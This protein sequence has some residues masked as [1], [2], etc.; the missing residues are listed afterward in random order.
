LLVGATHLPGLASDVELAKAYEIVTIS[1]V[2]PQAAIVRDM[3]AFGRKLKT[4]K[5]LKS[6]SGLVVATQEDQ[7]GFA[8]EDVSASELFA[9][10][11]K[12]VLE[13]NVK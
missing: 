1:I 3:I 5:G 12:L 13:L 10:A 8:A 4:T 7:Q 9:L 2:T 11:D 6:L